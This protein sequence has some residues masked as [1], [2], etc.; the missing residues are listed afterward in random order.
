MYDMYEVLIEDSDSSLELQ[1]NG[2]KRYTILPP[3]QIK[4]M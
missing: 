3:T 4:K 2:I 1:E